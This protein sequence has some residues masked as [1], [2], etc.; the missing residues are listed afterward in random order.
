M[1]VGKCLLLFFVVASSRQAFSTTHKRFDQLHKEGLNAYGGKRWSE[2]AHLIRRAIYQY[3]AS[4]DELYS[5]VRQ[6][7]E[8]KMSVDPDKGGNDDLAK[9]QLQLVHVSHCVKKCRKASWKGV[10][11]DVVHTLTSAYPLTTCNSACIRFA[12][13]I[14]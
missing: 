12:A 7:R 3:N 4:R 9:L 2:A 6:C 10:A 1:V 5:C 11:S 8:S 13:N 14:L